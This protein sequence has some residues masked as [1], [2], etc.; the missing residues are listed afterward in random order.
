MYKN[1]ISIKQEALSAGF[2]WINEIYEE[3]N[4]IQ[5]IAAQNLS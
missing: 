1:E 4:Y 2:M 3:M 5:T